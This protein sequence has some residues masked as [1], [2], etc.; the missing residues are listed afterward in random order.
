[1]KAT[2]R[3]LRPDP[4]HVREHFD[5]DLHIMVP[6]RMFVDKWLFERVLSLPIRPHHAAVQLPPLVPAPSQLTTTLH[7][8]PSA[9]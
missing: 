2:V 3:E 4:V 6:P 7:P 8:Q 5:G 1:L 9:T